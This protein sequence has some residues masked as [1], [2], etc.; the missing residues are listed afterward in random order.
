MTLNISIKHSIVIS[1]FSNTSTLLTAL[2]PLQSC[3][4][5]LKRWLSRVTVIIETLLHVKEDV[6]L[7]RLE[8]VSTNIDLSS[9]FPPKKVPPGD[10]FNVKSTFP[11][12]ESSETFAR[13]LLKIISV[14]GFRILESLSTTAHL[15]RQLSLFFLC[16]F[17]ILKSGI[18]L[19]E[20]TFLQ[21]F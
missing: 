4:L 3:P 8:E 11:K 10:P 21:L 7:C 16:V 17:H 19:S 6:L 9:F 13:F 15:Q 18:I 14:T 1:S 2:I 20:K 5:S 12:F